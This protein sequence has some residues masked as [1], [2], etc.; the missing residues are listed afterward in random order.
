MSLLRG[1]TESC[2]SVLRENKM[3]IFFFYFDYVWIVKRVMIELHMT[4]VYL[5]LPDTVRS[6]LIQLTQI[7]RIHLAGQQLNALKT[8]KQLLLLFCFMVE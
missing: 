1:S 3:E 8:D 5:Q 6:F 2:E 7:N 4:K